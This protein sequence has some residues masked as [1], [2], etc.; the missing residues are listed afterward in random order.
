MYSHWADPTHTDL[1]DADLRLLHDEGHDPQ[2]D[3]PEHERLAPDA[4]HRRDHS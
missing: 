2:R 3:L 1:S 4:T